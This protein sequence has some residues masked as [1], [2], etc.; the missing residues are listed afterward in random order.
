MNISA[1]AKKAMNLIMI[2]PSLLGLTDAASLVDSNPCY[3]STSSSTSTLT[4]SNVDYCDTALNSHQHR[5]QS[6]Q[7]G[8]FTTALS[9]S[10]TIWATP[11][12]HCTRPPAR[13]TH[14]HPHT[15]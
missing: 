2:L 6:E 3:T 1:A 8:H 7:A 5:N 9:I 10:E 11:A 13:R 15:Q 4:E 12:K 14:T